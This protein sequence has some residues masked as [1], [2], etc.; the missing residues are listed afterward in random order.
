LAY[1]DERADSANLQADWR[2][3][4][5]SAEKVGERGQQR[6]DES[7]DFRY[8]LRGSVRSNTSQNR[9]R[10]G[11]SLEHIPEEL[12]VDFVVILDFG[13]LDECAE[14]PRATIC[15]GLLQIRKPGLYVFSE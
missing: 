14:Q 12:V 4:R 13:S 5:W 11:R 8:T 2:G 3:E 6:F 15:R 10:A 1:A 7:Y 9:D